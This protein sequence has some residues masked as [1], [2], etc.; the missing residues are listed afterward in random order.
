MGKKKSNKT[1]DK[2]DGHNRIILVLFLLF[3]IFIGLI[4]IDSFSSKKDLAGEAVGGYVCK[5]NGGSCTSGSG[6]CSGYC[7]NGVC[8]KCTSAANC[9]D[10]NMCT[11]DKCSLGKCKH[12][13]ANEGV[14]CISPSCEVP[15]ECKGVVGFCQSGSCVEQNH[16]EY[17]LNA[18]CADE[19]C[20]I[21]NLCEGLEEGFC[22]DKGS[23]KQE[24]SATV[25]D[26][27][28]C[29][30]PVDCM[31]FLPYN[32]PNLPVPESC[33]T[34]VSTFTETGQSIGEPTQIYV[35]GVCDQGYCDTGCSVVV[36]T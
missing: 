6:C 33:E 5:A 22:D 25:C 2:A 31:Y 19:E 24:R 14:I 13:N 18:K 34:L 16:P 15:E 10:G 36:S 8:K 29:R 27:A 32:C 30:M 35:D 4:L 12:S 28:V 7:S 26:G 1:I 11:N 17:C 9:N 21:P 23:C 20:V 3:V